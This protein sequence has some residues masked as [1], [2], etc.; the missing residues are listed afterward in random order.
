MGQAGGSELGPGAVAHLPVAAPEVGGHRVRLAQPVRHVFGT[1]L[2]PGIIHDLRDAGHFEAKAWEQKPFL[3]SGIPLSDIL[4]VPGLKCQVGGKSRALLNALVGTRL[5]LAFPA[6]EGGSVAAVAG[7]R[8]EPWEVDRRTRVQGCLHLL[9]L[10]HRGPASSVQLR[11]PRGRQLVQRVAQQHLEAQDA[12]HRRRGAAK[13]PEPFELL[14]Q[15]AMA[16]LAH[17][18]GIVIAAEVVVQGFELFR[19]QARP[20]QRRIPP[21]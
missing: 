14:G 16:Y 7:G 11:D 2:P 8:L 13:V 17:G 18:A 4:P 21:V 5:W 9:Q 1:G 10:L 3:F 20:L 6:H 15:L 19:R 12:F